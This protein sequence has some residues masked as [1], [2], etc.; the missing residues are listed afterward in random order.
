MRSFGEINKYAI[1]IH[2][3]FNIREALFKLH[4]DVFG[5][6]DKGLAIDINALKI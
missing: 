1:N 5:L 3:A 4:F 6:I 2:E